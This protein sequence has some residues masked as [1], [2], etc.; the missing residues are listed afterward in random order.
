MGDLFKLVYI[1]YTLCPIAKLCRP[2]R[3]SMS[4]FGFSLIVNPLSVTDS[5][6][7]HTIKKDKVNRIRSG[8][9]SGR[10]W[11]DI[12]WEEPSHTALWVLGLKASRTN[13]AARVGWK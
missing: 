6:T 3:C 10:R 9:L 2:S 7:T 13:K 12:G 5:L 1:V 11:R 4:S 8:W